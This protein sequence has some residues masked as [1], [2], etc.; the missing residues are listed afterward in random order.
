MPYNEIYS[1]Y[2]N[3]MKGETPMKN[4][5]IILL[6]FLLL[7]TSVSAFAAKKTTT[8]PAP[9]LSYYPTTPT[10][11]NVTVTVYYPS[12]AMVKQYKL[13]ST[14]I[15]TTYTAPVA[16]YSN[17]YFY[18]RYQTYTGYWSNLGG[19]NITNIDKTP[20]SD[21]TLTASTTLP[22]NQDVTVTI[23]FSSDST[24]R[25]YKIG[26]SSAWTAYS[27]PVIVTSNDTVYAK[28][29]DS[30]GNWTS[31]VSYTISNIDKEAPSAP[32]LTAGTPNPTTGA[33]NISI[34]YPA[35]ATVKEYKVGSFG[36][37]AGYSDSIAVN[38][39][40]I[41]YARAQDLAG[42][43]STE[44]SLAVTTIDTT[45]PDAPTVTSST[46]R[47]TDE[48]VTIAVNFSTDST[49]KQY[50]LSST[51]V[52]TEYT[53]PITL[54]K[55]DT[56]YAKSSDAAG[57]WS[58]ESSCVISN[59]VKTVMGYTVKYYSTDVSS[60]NS[61]VANTSTLNEIATATFNVDGYGTLTGTAPTDQINYASSN[62]IR[63]KLMVSNNFDSTIAK[64]LL[65][66]TTN[67]QTLK[68]NILNMLRTYN[69]TG[70]DIDIENIPASD[71]TYLTTLMSEIYGALKPLGYGVSIAVA[72]KT[73]DSSSATW[74]YA[75]DYKSLAQYSDFLMI[76][77]YDEH[78]PG[79]T[80][81]A[82]ASI[83]W[84]TS[85]VDYALT[86]VPKEK[87]ILGMAAYGYDWAGTTTKSYSINGCFNLASQYGS[88]IN[89][90]TT[91]KSKYFTYV[92][93]GV[94]HTVWFEDGDTIAYK[95]DLAN[96]RD[97][98]GVGIWRLGL[99]NANYW[100]M[101]RSKLNK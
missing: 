51:G 47:L 101:I 73:Y 31:E 94:T 1:D 97:L 72:A 99:E 91:T 6:V 95:L 90:D 54:N 64:Q 63:T 57:N 58:L 60:Y 24:T 41:V 88:T 86:V 76:M 75:Y 53:T 61:M 9:T 48:P 93:S 19:Y 29:S 12:T 44:S 79:G 66:S 46:T 84:V 74:N 59:I 28:A 85:V 87:I 16:I 39:N 67:R 100:T 80:P 26:S 18:A 49:V 2:V 4:K 23:G 71:R 96:S 68:N 14:G 42:N 77:A 40:T 25:Q 55:N 62:G 65:E 89:F 17:T 82:V 36:I 83:N 69:Y 7:A 15:W 27:V 34:T 10:N 20:P 5:I 56:V 22:T 8:P 33:V 43:W 3:H 32:T 78:Y 35:D 81:G 50:K 92:V 45:P 13:G 70:V 21:P 11:G 30:I 37:W 98:K 52:W 38:S